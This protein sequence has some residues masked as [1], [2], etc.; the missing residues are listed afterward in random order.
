MRAI[1]FILILLVSASAGV[2][3]RAQDRVAPDRAEVIEQVHRTERDAETSA[4]R[5]SAARELPRR[6]VQSDGSLI[7]LV[8]VR[9]GRPF[10][11][12][13]AN[14]RAAIWLGT[15]HIQPGGRTGLGA[16]GTGQRIGVWDSGHVLGDHIELS[17][18]V[19]TG[20]DAEVS[21]HATHVGGTLAATGIDPD[22][23]GMAYQAHLTS[24][25]WTNDATEM[26][27]EGENGLLHSN[28][29]YG[30][31]AGWHFGDV[32]GT[33]DGWYWLGDP[34][35]STTEDYVFGRYDVE[36]VQF[37]RVAHSYP[38]LLP[39]VAAGNDRGDG[40]PRTGTYRALDGDGNYQTFRIEDRPIPPDGGDSGLDTI[41]GAG[42]AKNVLTIGSMGAVNA[43]LRLSVFS[44]F[45]PTDDNRIKPDLVGIGEQVYSLSSA[46]T[47]AYGVSSGTSMST[48][49]VT[50]SLTLLQQYYRDLFGAPLRAATLKG[51]ALHT[52]DDRATP[53][54]DVRTGWG[55]LDAERAALHIQASAEN[56]SAIIEDALHDGEQ[57]ARDVVS[58]GSGALRLTLSWTDPP[59]TRLPAN[60]PS[61]IDDPEPR[62]RNDLDVRLIHRASGTEYDPYVLDPTD[63]LGPA[64]RGD[65]RVDPVEQIYVSEA[66]TGAYTIVVSHKGSLFGSSRQP[67][68]LVVSG[69][70]G[71]TLPAAI[72]H[73]KAAPSLDGVTLSWKSLYERSSG[74]FIVDRRPVGAGQSAADYTRIGEIAG[75]G[76]SGREYEVRDALSTAGVYLY[77]VRFDDGVGTYLLGTVEVNLPAP[78]TFAVL[79]SYPN[80]YRIATTLVIDLPKTQRVTVDVFDA[81]GRRLTAVYDGELRAGRH[82][83][84]VRSDSWASGVYLARIL[85]PNGIR[86]HRLIKH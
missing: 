43:S 37:D 84:V 9:E 56:P 49:T 2:T 3:A 34:D 28:H 76:S 36:A 19:D 80:P 52:A 26:L 17:G 45:G 79:S 72:A 25:T 38:Y 15:V 81:L 70:R 75:S 73:L 18:R 83:I 42:T 82:E 20:D 27:N 65:N 33:G 51:L 74:T 54:P 66:D 61:S 32:E 55:L 29:S 44:S 48:A 60:G 35:I 10:Y 21:S 53:G 67:F 4:A 40:G 24:Y 13:A 23:R 16:T 30:V 50:G 22:A 11:L 64:V 41:A 68:S 8:D 78:E 77:R 7:E 14:A 59:G 12:G 63:P 5:W 1:T 47:D 39:I 86:T 57:Y 6:I 69:T 58:D 31:L 71:A 46:R 85:T 62:L